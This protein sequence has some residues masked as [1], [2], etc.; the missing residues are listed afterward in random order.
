M[1]RLIVLCA[2]VSP[3]LFAANG[4]DAKPGLWEVTVSTT[5]SGITLPPDVL[6]RMTADQKAKI[7][8]GL[9]ARA[10]KG[11]INHVSRECIT[12][13]DLKKGAFGKA[14][15]QRC[16]FNPTVQTAKRQAGT[17]TCPPPSGSGEFDFQALSREQM[18]GT[19][20]V[21]MANAT[22]KVDMT[23]QWLGASC[24]AADKH[25]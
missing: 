15:D 10:A 18:R 24:A 25:D 8:A 21:K 19:I 1:K 2:C 4:L 14:Q 9:Q 16:T 3:A 12:A 23:S 22:I 13:E 7:L 6:D 20:T 17:V 5:P 11:P